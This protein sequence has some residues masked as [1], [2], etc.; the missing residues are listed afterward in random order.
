[1]CKPYFSLQAMQ[2]FSVEA[3]TSFFIENM[4]KATPTASISVTPSFIDT[5]FTTT[6]SVTLPA[7]KKKGNDIKSVSPETGP[8]K[9]L[10]D[11]QEP[12]PSPTQKKNP[13]RMV[14]EKKIENEQDDVETLKVTKPKS[15]K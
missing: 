3:L 8:Q 1:M 2:T 11:Q 5:A 6:C 10:L 9:R 12:A 7:T 15:K 14:R 13:P 4:N